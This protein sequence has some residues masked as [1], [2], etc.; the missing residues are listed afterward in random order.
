MIHTEGAISIFV[1]TLYNIR[2]F[3]HLSCV[4]YM[5]QTKSNAT[6]TILRGKKC[7]INYSHDQNTKLKGEI[8]R[9]TCLPTGL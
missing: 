4:P 7:R 9:P 6:P 8:C 2:I 5:D 3:Y 1:D